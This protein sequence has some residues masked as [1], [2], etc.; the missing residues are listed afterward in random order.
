MSIQSEINRISANVS[1]ALAATAEMGADVPAT[2]SSDDLG[3]LIRSIPKSSG[4]PIVDAISNDGV[5]YTAT[6]PNVTELYKGLHITIIPNRDSASTKATLNINGLGTKR[7]Y[8]NSSGRIGGFYTPD[9]ANFLTSGIA[10]TLIFAGTAWRAMNTVPYAPHLKGVVAVANGGTGAS[11]VAG[12]RANLGVPSLADFNALLARVEALE[13]GGGDTIT[14]YYDT[15]DEEFTLTADAGMTWAQF[16]YSAYNR[17]VECYAVGHGARLFEDCEDITGEP[18]DG[19]ILGYW[20]GTCPNCQW[21]ED[22]LFFVCYDDDGCNNA[23]GKNGKIMAGQH[24]YASD[25]LG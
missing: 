8:Y 1:D 21:N 9:E 24:Y 16:V 5:T 19:D 18:W 6:V 25:S 23:V 2:A 14:F 12:A 11:T 4:I 20:N 10:V 13:A 15:G 7:I 3:T 22:S 17:E